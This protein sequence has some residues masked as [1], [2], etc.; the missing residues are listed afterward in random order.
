MN[1]IVV[2]SSAWIEYLKG[3]KKGERVRELISSAAIYTTVFIAAEVFAKYAKENKNV[4][5]A[6]IALS[7]AALVSLNLEDAALT[8]Q[9]YVSQRSLHE[10]FGMADAHVVAIAK[11][12]GAT[13]LTCDNDFKDI[14]E[15]TV[16]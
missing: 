4:Q 3:S 10:K 1:K 12:I 6:V 11:K 9:P 2:D 14:P 13:I 8:A 5:D 16:I 7:T 15:A